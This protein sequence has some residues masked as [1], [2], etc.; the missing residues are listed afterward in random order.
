MRGLLT[1]FYQLMITFGILLA[2]AIDQVLIPHDNGWRWAIA[3]QA[4]PGF[5]LLTVMPFLPRSPRWLVQQGKQDE[6]LQCLLLVRDENE[7][8]AEL[9][10]IVLSHRQEEL[11]AEPAWSELFHGRVGKLLLIGVTLQLLQQL[12]GM[13]AFMYFGPRLFASLNFNANLMQTITNLVNFL[14]T[15]PALVMADRCGRRSLLV[16]SAAGMC[17][18][19]F[20]MGALGSIYLKKEASGAYVSSSATGNVAIVGMILF[21]VANF[22][23]GWGPI[24]WVYTSEIFPLRYRSRCVAT[25]TCSNWVGNYVIAQFTPIL[26]G[27][28]GFMTFYVFGIFCL[29]ALAM[30][31]WIPETKGVLLEHISKVFD[32]KL[33]IDDAQGEPQ[34]EARS[35]VNPKAN[36]YGAVDETADSNDQK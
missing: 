3:I 21:F 13:N 25:A 34:D 10:E 20:V 35:Q 4:I 19:C 27:S 14:A 30:S 17:I 11:M 36:T 8:E 33:G 16:S 5:L 23:Y 22:G 18:A 7:A 12:V 26:L 1:S 9:A 2:A 28:I 24:V 15:F 6:A 32:E 29:I 31:L